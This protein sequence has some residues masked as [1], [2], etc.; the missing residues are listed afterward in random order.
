MGETTMSYVTN[1]RGKHS[2]TKA[3][4]RKQ[5]R[6]DFGSR[7]NVSHKKPYKRDKQTKEQLKMNWNFA[8]DYNLY[9]EVA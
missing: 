4:S 9:K 5:G 7:D 1:I 8:N 3:K 6:Y 2:S